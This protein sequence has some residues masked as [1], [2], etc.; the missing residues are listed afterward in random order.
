MI[1][2]DGN[3]LYKTLNE[4]RVDKDNVS[5]RRVCRT[6]GI[7]HTVVTRLSH[8]KGISAN[9]LVALMS[10]FG[11]TNIEPYIMKNSK[12]SNE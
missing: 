10:Y 5:W 1:L 11:E 6:V 3:N 12:V 2:L 9:S 7:T 8:G 4:K